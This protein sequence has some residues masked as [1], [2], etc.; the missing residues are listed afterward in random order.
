MSNF[1][2]SGFP[3]HKTGVQKKG[4]PVKF[5]GNN[6]EERGTSTVAAASGAMQGAQAGAMF[7]PYGMAIGA[8][9]GGGA[10]LLMADKANSAAA[11]AERKKKVVEAGERKDTMK[12]EAIKS[13]EKRKQQAQ[14][15]VVD[16]S[17]QSG[18]PPAESTP[19]ESSSA[20]LGAL[21]S[22]IQKVIKKSQKLRNV[23][24]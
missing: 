15:G 22:P 5:I 14:V 21:Y 8:V 13:G 18:P 12:A 6:S 24:Y 9:V 2:M 3:S 17:G 7:G 16:F 1:K 4:S 20:N 23:K 11:E 19:I 10:G